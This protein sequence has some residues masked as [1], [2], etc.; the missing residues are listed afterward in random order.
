MPLDL[1]SLRAAGILPVFAAGN[2]GPGAGTVESP[3]NMPEPSPSAAPTTPTR[4]IPTGVAVLGLPRHH[5]AKLTAPA[6]GNRT[7]DLYGGYALDTGTSV[8]A[9]HVAGALALLLD[10]FPGL[11]ADQQEA[12]LEGG[13]VDRGAAGVDDEFGYGRLAAFAACQRLASSP[14]F[15]VSASPS[16]ASVSP[17]GSASY[18]VSVAGAN[19]STATSPSS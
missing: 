2:Y 6:V 3:A 18:A 17:G 9:P 19:G 4:C 12:A 10:A 14:D 15:T 5:S 8:A 11:T 7:A 1:R 16:T 13:A